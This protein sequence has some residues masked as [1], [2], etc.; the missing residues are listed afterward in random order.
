[1]KGKKNIIQ[2]AIPMMW[3][4]PSSHLETVVLFNKYQGTFKEEQM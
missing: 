1:V 2:F 3:H 4:E